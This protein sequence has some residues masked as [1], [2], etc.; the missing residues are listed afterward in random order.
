MLTQNRIVPIGYS[1]ILEYGKN[2]YVRTM[3]A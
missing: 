1:K 3:K 2:N